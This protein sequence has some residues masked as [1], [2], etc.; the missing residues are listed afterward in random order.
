MRVHA[1]NCRVVS[2][3]PTLDSA[4]TM[5]MLMPKLFDGQNASLMY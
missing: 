4:C 3:Y 2:K 1:Q 5:L